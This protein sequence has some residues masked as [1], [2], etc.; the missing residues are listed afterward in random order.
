MRPALAA[1]WCDVACLAAELW[2]VAAAVEPDDAGSALFCGV[3]WLV[4]GN[5]EGVARLFAAVDVTDVK[6][7]EPNLPQMASNQDPEAADAVPS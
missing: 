4:E 1:A 7:A 3:V 5:L 2:A 6:G